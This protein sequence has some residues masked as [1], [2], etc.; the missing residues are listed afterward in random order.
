M[1]YSVIFQNAHAMAKNLRHLFN[2]YRVAF[3][4]ALSQEMKQAWSLIKSGAT[5][6]KNE[7]KAIT[8]AMISNVAKQAMENENGIAELFNKDSV[9]IEIQDLSQSVS[10]LVLNFHIRERFSSCNVSTL[11]QAKAAIDDFT[12]SLT[13]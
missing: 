13:A 3:S 8:G 10:Y 11:D 12:N 7:I 9:K 2:S 1:N 5:E 6:L 4:V